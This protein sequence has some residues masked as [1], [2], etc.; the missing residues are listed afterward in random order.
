MWTVFGYLLFLPMFLSAQPNESDTLKLKA[1][2]DLTGIWQGGNVQTLIFRAKSDVT[3]KPWKKWVFNTKNSYVYQ[4]F[5]KQKADEDVLSLN[6][7][8]FNPEKSVYPF[9]LG[10]ASSNFRRQIDLRYLLGLGATFQLLRAKDNWL[11]M[12]ISSEY[13]ETDFKRATF[14]RTD[15]NVSRT[16]KTLRSTLWVNGKHTLIKD[17]MLITHESF[18]QPSVSQGDNFRWRFEAGL[19]FPSWKFLEFKISYLHTDES[20]VIE[21]Q[22]REDGFLTFGLMVKN[23]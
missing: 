18:F 2:L 14:N 8:Y 22:K 6:F 9:L 17:K 19:N 10:I 3:Y 11:K 4:A 21:G 1:K 20:I 5:G 12:S 16:I 23:Y 15:Y 7:L 13:E